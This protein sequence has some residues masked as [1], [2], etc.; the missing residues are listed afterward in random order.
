MIVILAEKPSQ[1][2][3]YADIFSNVKGQEGYYQ[4]PS[5]SIFPKGAKI[6]WGI[7]HLV[8]LK[9]PHEYNESWKHWRME[10]L[11]L[12]PEKFQFK[13]ADDKKKQFKIVKK[14]LDEATQIIIA[15]DCDRE[16][17]NIARSIIH[18]AGASHKPIKRLWFNSLEEDELLRAFRDL[19]EGQQYISYYHEAQARQISDWIVGL[20]AS[21]LYTLLFKETGIKEVF[22][23]G[24]VQT[25]TLKLIYDRQREIEGFVPK[26]F[27]ELEAIFTTQKGCYKGRY[28]EKTDTK[29]EM[30][31]KLVENSI[32]EGKENKAKI[33]EVRKEIKKLNPPKLH[34]L[35]SLQSLLNKK[36]KYSPSQVLAIVQ[37]LYDTPLKL[38]TYPRTDTQ[39]ITE[40]EF[41][42]LKEQLPS[43]QRLVNHVF[44]PCSLQPNKRYV[45]GSKVQ[46]HYAIIPTRKIPSLETLNSLTNEQRIVY[47][48]ILKSVLA[49]FH[50]PYVYEETVIQTEMNS[51]LFVTKGKVEKEKGWKELYGDGTDGTDKTDEQPT[52]PEVTKG[53]FCTG[54]VSIHEGKT[55]P[56]KRYTQGQ[57][58]DVMKTCGRIVDELSDE[59]KE[60]LKNV[61]GLGTEAT[62][63][64]IIDN[65]IKQ[66]YI[67]VKKNLV[68][69]TKKGEILCKLLEGTLLTKPELTAKWESYL[70]K[71]G[72]GE[73]KKEV[74][75]ANTIRFIKETVQR[76]IETIKKVD[77]EA[78]VGAIKAKDNIALCP[79]CKKGYVVE[80]NGF[81]GCTEYKNG[82]KQT[83]PQKILGKNI[84]KSHVKHLCEKGKTNKIK[85][86][87]GKTI[88]DAYLV[89][90]DGKINFSFK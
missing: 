20:N 89:L 15:T 17:E 60:I 4:V 27:F 44:E 73:G 30:L 64:T 25:P 43:Y 57:L 14:L 62:R 48:E 26:Q 59:D 12:L 90:E 41:N 36:Y 10:D 58:I 45:D 29:E 86:F 72:Q 37:T 51:F 1:A 79:A 32:V 78:D 83:F 22:P 85:G 66:N 18:Y 74:F 9:E 38:V 19:R 67:E 63:S 24:R 23:V 76:S 50:A 87:K 33:H 11:P 40:H 3:A 7:G 77:V 35:S 54:K 34:S 55:T 84:T 39:Y 13:V 42:Y 6:T 81:Y 21:R 69:V 68:Y 49:M 88:F 5:C 80:K 61:E 46:E 8:T 82:C 52:L 65:L 75:I 56:P 16:G 53:E 28:V 70:Q 2:K 71:I 31:K 47:F